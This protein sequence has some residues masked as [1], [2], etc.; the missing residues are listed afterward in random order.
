MRKLILLQIFLFISLH[1]T[2][3]A[4]FFN[5]GGKIKV[6][7]NAEMYIKGSVLNDSGYFNNN[8]L[9]IMMND[10]INHTVFESGPDSYVKLEGD[11]QEVGG[12]ELIPFWHLFISGTNNKD[13]T[14][15]TQINDSLKFIQNKIILADSNITLTFTGHIY[16]PSPA[17]HIVTIGE[18]F[19]VKK[20]VPVGTDYLFPVSDT[21]NTYK[22]V[23][24]NY[25]G[26]T[27]TFA[28]RVKTGI[29]PT[30]GA[31][32]TTVYST[33]Y[34]HESNPGGTSASLS[35]GWNT[36][37]EQPAF[38]NSWALMWRNLYGVWHPQSG[39]PGGIINQPETDWYYKVNGLT[40]FNP[41]NAAFMI[42]SMPV[43]TITLKPLPAEVCEGVDAYFTIDAVSMLQ[44]YYQWQVNCGGTW[45]DIID[46]I[47]Y[48][49][50]Q[51]NYLTIRKPA[52]SMNGCLYRCIVS[53]DAGFQMSDVVTLT[54][55]P[56]P[57]AD[58]YAVETEIQV[59]HYAEFHDL[60]TNASYWEWE[61]GEG[62]TSTDQN[63]IQYYY[64]DG[65]YSVTLI[66]TSP[67]GCKDTLIRKDYIDVVGPDIYV[68]SLFTPN[69]DGVND[70]LY[71]RGEKI[72]NFNFAVYN[73]LGIELFQT[74]N[75]NLGWAGSS[76]GV[77]H[78]DGNYLWVVTGLTRRGKI[79]Q[80]QGV[81]TI[82]K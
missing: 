3:N 64:V 58:F 43:P 81:V 23:I 14:G 41:P 36:W 67:D 78:P 11:T 45:S 61:F 70:V 2:L 19:L 75:Q 51:T 18:G 16:H 29:H 49:G 57:L 13:F 22:P 44:V 35:L 65:F 34:I 40:G 46:D 82:A 77:M 50:S 25:I 62:S 24:L 54:V 21:L 6:C 56:K 26:N 76:G 28:V 59:Q 66:V 72:E 73:Q 52:Y 32:T 8:G 74:T 48:S 71:V 1:F 63:P 47:T 55:F 10:F 42:R 79:I 37:D 69:G 31:D 80:E 9:I 60:S 33:F 38:N 4:Q 39:N 27:D 68:P 20:M 7:K 30:T 5:N 15:P 17:K 53:N 12:T